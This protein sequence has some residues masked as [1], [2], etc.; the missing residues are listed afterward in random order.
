M[1]ETL[2][3]M[4]VSLQESLRLSQAWNLELELFKMGFALPD[5]LPESLRLRVRADSRTHGEEPPRVV[6]RIIC[7]HCLQHRWSGLWSREE[8]QADIVFYCTPT[9]EGCGGYSI[10]EAPIE[11][12]LPH[13]REVNVTG[14]AI[15][16]EEVAEYEA[17]MLE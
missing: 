13:L 5:T 9:R 3:Q 6:L 14:Y 2:Q 8:M 7:P 17:E 10:I 12:R 15:T 1:I 4:S 16:P 11:R